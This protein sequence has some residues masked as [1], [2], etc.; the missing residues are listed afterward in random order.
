[1]LVFGDF[2]L[3][4]ARRELRRDGR[5]INIRPTPFRVLTLL[6]RE[7]GRTLAKQELLDAIWPGVFV[8]DLA[9]S[10]AINAVRQAL[11]DDGKTQRWLQTRRGYGYQFVGR[12]EERSPAGAGAGDGRPIRSLAVLPLEN[13]SGDPAQEY[14]ADGMTEALIGDLAKL[15]GLRVVSRTSV[16]RYKGAR[17]P[18]G[19]IAT[20]LKVDAVIEGTASRHGE[21]AR[22]SVQL[23]DAQDDGHLWAETY[24]RELGDILSIQ[25]EIARAVAEQTRI[26]LEPET[27]KYFSTVPRIDPRAHDAHFKGLHQWNKL[28]PDSLWHAVDHFERAIALA[29]EFAPAHVGL[30]AVYVLLG[31]YIV[32]AHA[33]LPKAREAALRALKLD[34]C[35][36]EAYDQLGW[37]SMSYDWNWT[38]AEARFQR[39]I[40][41]NPENERAYL[42]YGVLLS[43]RGEHDAAIAMGK[44]RVDLAPLDH[45]G[46]TT[47]ASV[48]LRN[49]RAY[50][51]AVHE[52]KSILALDPSFQFARL[53][54]ARLLELMGEPDAVEI[55]LA[56]REKLGT[57]PSVIAEARE[58]LRAGGAQQARRLLLKHYL[59]ASERQFVSP[60]IIAECY[61]R[62]DDFEAALVWLDRAY[63]ERSRD[64]VHLRVNPVVDPLRSDP[65]YTRLVERIG[66]PSV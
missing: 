53:E 10:S 16:M 64:L 9:L 61:L 41:L 38:E 63:A 11:D 52:L 17:S 20:E 13:L 1:V 14:F 26:V 28:T 39:A 56:A 35:S 59:R 31:G 60:W 32:S 58:A 47:Y 51:R 12:V 55:E 44:R 45:V 23:I 5:V 8:G 21:R 43:S 25:S 4:E 22:V 54:L 7:R 19:Q 29:P 36:A 33:A 65:R 49:A 18:L 50:D 24:D 66:I 40:E 30:S 15:D 42:G 37:V 6:V 2:E 3:D 57:S 46:H 34:P 48:I 27:E 62:L